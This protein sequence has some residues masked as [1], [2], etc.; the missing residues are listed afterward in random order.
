[1]REARTSLYRR[2]RPQF[3]WVVALV[4]IGGVFPS[5]LKL[6]SADPIS[7]RPQA[8]LRKLPDVSIDSSGA[9]PVE[10]GRS[11]TLCSTPQSTALIEPLP[12]PKRMDLQL[13]NP[14]PVYFVIGNVVSRGVSK[15]KGWR[16]FTHSHVVGLSQKRVA[17]NPRMTSGR[18]WRTANLLQFHGGANS[19]QE[20]SVSEELT[21]DS[22]SSTTGDHDHETIGD[23]LK[24]VYLGN[25]ILLQRAI[26]QA[27]ASEMV[28][29]VR[30][31]L[32]AMQ[33]TSYH[34]APRFLT[35]IS[36]L[37]ASDG[38]ISFLSLY[39]LSLLGASCGFY[40]L[41]YFITFGYA[42]GVGL[43][44]TVS[45]YVYNKRSPLPPAT[46]YHSAITILWSLRMFAFLFWRE[47]FSWPAL[48]QKVVNIQSRMSIPFASRLLCWLLYSAFYVTM[49]TMNWSRLRQAATF[50]DIKKSWGVVGYTG[51][52]I[53]TLG[54]GL[55]TIADVQKN[56]FKSLHRHTWCNVGVWKWSTHPHYLGEGL[57]WWGTYLAHG[58]HS[59][60]HTVLATIGL[61]FILSVLR[62]STRSLAAKQIEKYGDQPAYFE[63]QRRHSFWGPKKLRWWIH[64]EKELSQTNLEGVAVQSS[65]NGNRTPPFGEGI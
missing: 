38:V 39:G 46:I 19:P 23:V 27:K 29:R 48:H 26:L 64:K 1:M 20:S 47:F 18:N 43:P 35:L 2:R 61:T 17:Y 44:L 28:N 31:G 22:G 53:Q 13:Q 32:E 50:H 36:V 16:D 57:F 33:K 6:T 11:E 51:L 49:M 40:L 65:S 62:G 3:V 42:L 58:F 56:R 30:A 41:L 8:D 52:L 7:R 59:T 9:L 12:D 25:D 24:G 63:F 55:E 10:W 15:A 45:L 34:V 5:G 4:I 54:L 21:A 37:Y 60:P 14:Q